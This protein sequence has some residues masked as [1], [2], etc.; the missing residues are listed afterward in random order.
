MHVVLGGCL[1]I[2]FNLYFSIQSNYLLQ[3]FIEMIPLSVSL[4][5]FR[6]LLNFEK[7]LAT[8]K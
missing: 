2:G 3:Y 8:A 5:I 6:M 1:G 4:Q 7:K